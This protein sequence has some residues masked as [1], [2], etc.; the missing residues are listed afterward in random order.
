[1]ACRWLQSVAIARRVVPCGCLENAIEMRVRRL[2]CEG[3]F[4]R[5]IR[6]LVLVLLLL[7]A[8]GLHALIL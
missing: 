3:S 7:V 1:M 8:P 4:H 5:R 2:D 6:L